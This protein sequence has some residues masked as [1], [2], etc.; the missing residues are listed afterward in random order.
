[1]ITKSNELKELHAGENF[2]HASVG[3]PVATEG[4]Q[5]IKDVIGL[6]G[7]EISFGM[8]ESGQAV[9]FFHS[10]KQNE[11]VYIVLTG[12]GDFQVDEDVFPIEAGSIVRVAAAGV[13]SLKCTSTESLRYICIQSKTGSLE[14]CTMTDGIIVEYKAMWD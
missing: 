4:K 10:H 8:L 13:R 5:F 7:S 14:Q 3:N 2:A 1:M 9:P 11:E 6:T 12:A